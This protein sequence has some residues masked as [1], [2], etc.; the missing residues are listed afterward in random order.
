MN[1]S[2]W[3]IVI[4]GG[5]R[6]FHAMDWYRAVCRICPDRRVDFVTDMFEAEGLKSLA[7]P[8]DNI[9]SL[10]IIDWILMQNNST[11]G[12]IWRNFIKILFFPIQIVMF[13]YL[14]Y[15]YNFNIVHAHP[16]YYMLLC[17]FSGIPY[18]G[19]P[20]GDELLIRPNRSKIYRY[21]ASI[22]LRGAKGVVVDSMQMKN[23]AK[24][25]SGIDAYLIQNGVNVKEILSECSSTN[26]QRYRVTSIRGIEKL[27]RI[28]EII[29]HRNQYISSET[30]TLLYPF[31]DSSYS[32]M[33]KE[34]LSEKDMDLGRLDK[35]QMYQ[36]FRESLLV[37]SVPS[38]DS[39]PRS[40]YEAIFA[41]CCVATT[42]NPWIDLLP[43]CMR[44]R[45]YIINLDDTDWLSQAIDFSK[46]N[47]VDLFKPSVKAL[48]LFDEESSIRKVID[49]L[50]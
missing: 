13:R 17:F 44:S 40:V 46:Q 31:Y 41:G 19:T 26:A 43:E 37:I 20:Q 10:F 11:L 45:I 9:T 29:T 25:I 48:E 34:L 36:V 28:K 42:Y 4:L 3:D 18:I 8:E 30:L 14:Y 47:V 39:S 32:I 35:Q 49:T 33:I 12:N 2:K 15:K 23:A 38:S 27:Y 1:S 16:M 24:N 6:D 7:E 21:F 5:V 22:V 50:Y